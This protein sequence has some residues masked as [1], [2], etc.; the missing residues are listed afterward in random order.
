MTYSVFIFLLILTSCSKKTGV[1]ISQP[2]TPPR[3]MNF[4]AEDA[5][6]AMN[7]FDANFYSN[8]D[9][10]YYSSTQKNKLA[11][12]WVQAIYWDMIMNTYKRS[13]APVDLQRVEDLYQG[14]YLKYDK[15]N[16]ENKVEWFIYD[17]MMWWIISLARAYEITGQQKYL[18]A[19][20]AGF[21]RVW[22]DSYDVVNGGMFWDFARTGKMACINFPTVIGAT[23]LYNITKD[24]GYLEK[25]KEI[26]AWTN[27]TLFDKKS[28]LVADHKVGDNPTY[29]KAHTYNQA[30]C[31]GA[32][33]MLYKATKDQ[34]YLNDAILAADYTQEFMSSSTGVLT[35]EMGIEQGIYNAILA[36]YIIRLIEDGNQPKYESWIRH[37]IDL[38]WENR[39]KARGIT[40]KEYNVPCPIGIVESYDASGIPAFMQVISPV[41]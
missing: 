24:S 10:L 17:D 27:N 22:R 35:F 33:V 9:K 29:W 11:A 6:A 30:T 32:G 21:A 1:G 7:S 13:N 25:A 41:K 39:D 3:I 38:G 14:G 28:G 23:T 37:N 15:Y 12:I 8:T 31:I 19:S 34:K 16:W 26:Y 4:T 5:K 2:I 18:N 36:Q 40:Y 20:K